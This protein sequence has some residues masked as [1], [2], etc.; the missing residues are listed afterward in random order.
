MTKPK[1]EKETCDGFTIEELEEVM[2]TIP[3]LR[4]KKRSGE[5]VVETKFPTIKE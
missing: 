5:D 4:D 3:G 2:D 1:P